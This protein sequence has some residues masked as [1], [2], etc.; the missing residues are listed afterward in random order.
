MLLDK[1]VEHILK[2]GPVYEVVPNQPSLNVLRQLLQ[3]LHSL[4]LRHLQLLP[5]HLGPPIVLVQLIKAVK[6]GD[7]VRVGFALLGEY[8]ERK[9]EF[10]RRDDLLGVLGT[11]QV[12]LDHIDRAEFRLEVLRGCGGTLESAV[13]QDRDAVTDLLCFVDPMR[14]EQDGSVPH[15]A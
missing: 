8:A 12:Q 11:G 15:A 9:G 4:A 14:D 5:S 1:R 10:H 2:R 6:E 7:S 3:H 13:L